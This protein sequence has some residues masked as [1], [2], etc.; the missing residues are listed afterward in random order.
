MGFCEGP[1]VQFLIEHGLWLSPRG[2]KK[3]AKTV[4]RFD[5]SRPT[6]ADRFATGDL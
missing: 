5:P 1:L 6:P 3:L 4:A 2:R